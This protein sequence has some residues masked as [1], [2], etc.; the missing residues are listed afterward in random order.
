MARIT[1][2]KDLLKHI[3]VKKAT[4]YVIHV[5]SAEPNNQAR[6]RYGLIAASLVEAV[7]LS[8]NRNF[9]GYIPTATFLKDA[10]TIFM[11]KAS[12]ASL[13]NKSPLIALKQAEEW[14]NVM[15]TM[16][17][18][19]NA[20]LGLLYQEEEIMLPATDPEGKFFEELHEYIIKHKNSYPPNQ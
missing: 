3:K 10:I 11:A 12:V 19:L 17:I 2:V 13:S 5:L 16:G 18:N 4:S 20:L 8:R 1:N 15:L 9:R 6:E 7:V 14:A